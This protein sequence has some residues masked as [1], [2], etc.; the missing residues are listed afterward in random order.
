MS[1]YVMKYE[2]EQQVIDLQTKLAEVSGDWI[3]TQYELADC[4]AVLAAQRQQ[5]ID[6]VN[7]VLLETGKVYLADECTTAIRALGDE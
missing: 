4:Q 6:A 1:D 2:L 7:K 3:K 5:C